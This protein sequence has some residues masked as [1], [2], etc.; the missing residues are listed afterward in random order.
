MKH[1]FVCLLFCWLPWM[2]GATTGDSLHYLTPKDTIFLTLDYF[3]EKIFQHRLAPKQTLFSLARFYGLHLEELYAYNPGLKE[4]LSSLEVG[5]PI[6]IPIPNR[7]ILRF[8]S[9]YDNPAEYI[10]VIY[11]VKK[12]DTV[13]RI[14]KNYFKIPADTLL[15]RNHLSSIDLSLHQPL[16][17]GYMSILGIP[18][19]LRQGRG[20][21]LWSQ[22]QENRLTY[23]AVGQQKREAFSQ[24]IAHWDPE[25]EINTG[26]LVVLYRNAPINSYVA[27][28]NPMFNRTVYARV[29][30]SVP[31]QHGPD[32]ITVVPPAIAKMLGAI[33]P[34][35]YVQVRYLK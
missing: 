7:A 11:R 29:I 25:E 6:R 33:D 14:C 17:V 5:A 32:V 16:H 21:P 26:E 30:G 18:D 31:K 20:G 35:F 10:P 28:T 24:G 3:G 2:S 1:S 8:L 19:S 12:G 9:P 23:L 27:I 15:A 34:N 13:Y 22:S 4:N